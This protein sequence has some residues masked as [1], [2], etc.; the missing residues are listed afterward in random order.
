MVRRIGLCVCLL[1]LSVGLPIQAAD[2]YASL[3]AQIKAA[4][5]SG[6]GRITLEADILL[7]S[8]LE[9]IT[10]DISVEGGGHSI[11]GDDQFRIFDV[12]GGSLAI[13][14]ATLTEGRAEAGGA[15]RMRNGA[16]VTINSATLRG[17]IAE[18]NGGAIQALGGTLQISQSRFENNC[19]KLLTSTVMPTGTDRILETVDADGCVHIEQIVRR[20]EDDKLAPGQGGAIHLADGANAAIEAS[21]FSG[22]RASIGGAIAATR[23]SSRLSIDRSSFISNSASMTGG[24]ALADARASDITASSFVEN[25]ARLGGGSISTRFGKLN[26]S[27]SSFSDPQS[28]PFASTVDI[29]SDADVTIT[30]ATL[31]ITGSL[32]RRYGAI[33]KGFDATLRLRNSII[34]GPGRG[35]DCVGEIEEN[36]NNLSTD[37]SCAI[38]ASDDPLLGEL[39]GSPAYYPPLDRSP[40]IDAADPR[41]CP[42]T[43]QLGTARNKDS[44]DIGA[45]EATGADNMDAPSGGCP[46]GNGAD[47]ISLARDILLFAPLPAI[48]SDIT[49]QGKGHTISGDSKFRIFDVDRG[50]LTIKNLTLIDGNAPT[51]RGGAIRLGEYSRASVSASSFIGN[52]AEYG[53]AIGSV[54]LR[55]PRL[56]LT[57]RQS[58]FIGNK[59]TRRGGAIAIHAG[60]ASIANSSFAGNAAKYNGGAIYLSYVPRLDVTNSSFLDGSACCG[61]SA[62]AAENGTN[63]TLTHVTMYNRYPAGSGVELYTRNE[64]P[65][66]PPNNVR[67][68]NSIIAEAGPGYV[69]LCYGGLTQNIGSIIEGGACSP[70]LDIDPMLEEPSGDSAWLAPLP[71]S[72][73]IGAAD[74]RFCTAADQLGNPRSQAG[75]CDIGAIE[76]R[77]VIVDI[78]N[79]QVT[80]THSLNF[81][82]APNGQRT[83]T[84]PKAT[85]LASRGRTQGWFNVEQE[86]A[87]GWISAD[88]V[89]TDGACG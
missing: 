5:K 10:G 62:L 66:R 64:L 39:T 81:R 45:I 12:N 34:K 61:G 43:D 52:L 27:N 49:I 54:A 7:S 86:G 47:T 28:T 82:D 33:E 22:N 78:A 14:N 77:P 6:S 13:K 29:M 63:A 44:C 21:T 85:T 73:A 60:S 1:L 46:A 68:R 59:A 53:G 89:T 83:G 9:T 87:S 58:R 48:T 70:I 23:T 75:P 11:S 25:A 4:N 79:C 18:T 51:G 72:P 76:A 69:V 19:V 2:D 15:I 38:K 3:A 80:T 32:N 50:H 88:Y 67:L 56:Q 35:E 37:G 55:Q 40:A 42:E 30:H 57:V 20:A 84:V 36:I 16:R 17:N 41:F 71:G 24:A 65:S 8:P 74:P 26:I 31:V